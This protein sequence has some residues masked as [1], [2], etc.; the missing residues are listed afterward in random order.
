MQYN[1]QSKDHLDPDTAFRES[2]F[3]ALADDEGAAFW[4]GVYGQPIHTYSPYH[5]A[6]S[7][8]NDPD[9]DEDP[10]NP[11]LER[12]SDE[13][14]VSYVRGKM[15]EK[16]HQYIFEERKRREEER[17]RR[18]E[19]E[20]EG[21]RWQDRMDEAIR[22]GEEKKRRGRWNGVWERY[23]RGWDNVFTD[24][25]ASGAVRERIPWPVASGK[26]EEVCKE[27]VERFFMHAPQAAAG[28]QGGVDLMEVLKKER[29]RWHPD[30]MM[31]RAGEGGLNAETLKEVTS[32]FQVVDGMLADMRKRAP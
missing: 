27:E 28:G 25:G 2:L 9:D 12:M 23:G 18:E 14:Y 31:Q 20:R 15:W 1:H 32:V 10:D 13:E 7:T 16:S 24:S 21:R 26:A 29:V 17:R 30:K 6:T 19:R 4:E 3:D 8:A 5:R 22:R 11:R